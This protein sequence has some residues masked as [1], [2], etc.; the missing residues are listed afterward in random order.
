MSDL[1]WLAGLLEGEGCFGM[2]KQVSRN[3]DRVYMQPRIVL[4]MTDRDIVDRAHRMLGKDPRMNQN[5]VFVLPPTDKNK[6]KYIISLGGPRAIAWM[7]TL[8]S[9]MGTRRRARIRGLLSD[10]RSTWGRIRNRQPKRYAGCHPETLH[11]A[12]GLCKPCYQHNY[13]RDYRARVKA[14]A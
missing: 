14:S 2:T 9:L 6:A 11:F 12:F 5:N 8:Y 10:W 3:G 7:M 4:G 13:N 1:H